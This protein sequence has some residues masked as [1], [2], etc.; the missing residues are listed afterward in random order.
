MSK[1]LT[2]Q[3]LARRNQRGVA[4]IIALIMLMVLTMIAVV[5]MR[6]TTLDLKMSTNQTLVETYVSNFRSGAR[7][8]P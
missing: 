7:A 4:L 1:Y 2:N 3:S 8:H 6:T 5:A